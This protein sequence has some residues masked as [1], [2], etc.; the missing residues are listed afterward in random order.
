MTHENIYM[1]AFEG[2][3]EKSIKEVKAKIVK[4]AEALDLEGSYL[5]KEI[6]HDE[7]LTLDELLDI[8]S[9]EAE[10]NP[11]LKKVVIAIKV[12]LKKSKLGK[13]KPI[14]ESL[15]NQEIQQN[16]DSGDFI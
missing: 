15:L 3:N 8:L 7:N 14:N 2:I 11:K 6:G 16:M 10:E 4:D 9:F 1:T 12:N 13:S 5:L